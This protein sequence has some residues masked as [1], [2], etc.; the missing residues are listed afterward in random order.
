MKR[1]DRFLGLYAQFEPKLILLQMICHQILYYCGLTI[2]YL[3]FDI[4]FGVRPHFGQFFHASIYDFSHTYGVIA[5]I[6]NFL[7]IFVMI[8]GL[9][10]ITEKGNKV[11]DFVLTVY[12]FH[13]IICAFYTG[14][15]FLGW[16]W[17]I[18]NGSFAVATI[19]L[20]EYICLRLE[21]QEINLQGL[22]SPRGGVICEKLKSN[23]VGYYKRVKLFEGLF[24][25]AGKKDKKEEKIEINNRSELVELRNIKVDSLDSISPGVKMA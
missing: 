8:V 17:F 14:T 9:I 3:I 7:N 21:Q 19:L 2:F 24:T 6:A 22:F 20:G 10:F 5:M 25:P 23:F 4:S 12:F 11:L 16:S 13:F 1:K 15:I 18:F